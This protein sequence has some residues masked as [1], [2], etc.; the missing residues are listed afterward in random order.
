MTHGAVLSVWPDIW[1]N[2][3]LCICICAGIFLKMQC[4][5]GETESMAYYIAIIFVWMASVSQIRW[6]IPNLEENHSW[7]YSSKKEKCSTSFLH[8]TE[9]VSLFS[10]QLLKGYRTF[11]AWAENHGSQHNLEKGGTIWREAGICG[12]DLHLCSPPGRTLLHGEVAATSGK[13]FKFA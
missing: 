4:P 8:F 7:K 3:S 1:Q 11:E 5:L 13:E 2:I 12:T 10:S 9:L 6:N